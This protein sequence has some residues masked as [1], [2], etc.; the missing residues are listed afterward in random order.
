[1]TPTAALRRRVPA[2]P[3]QMAAEPVLPPDGE[4]SAPDPLTVLESDALLGALFMGLLPALAADLQA[5]HITRRAT[6]LDIVFSVVANGPEACLS[7]LACMPLLKALRGMMVS[8]AA[9]QPLHRA[10]HWHTAY[11][12][13]VRRSLCRPSFCGRSLCRRSPCCR[14]PCRRSLCRRLLCHRSMKLPRLT[15]ATHH[16]TPHRPCCGCTNRSQARTCAS[17]RCHTR[18]STASG[19]CA[20]CRARHVQAPSRLGPARQMARCT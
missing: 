7:I 12:A 16:L 17:A 6:A 15:S 3:W 14:L 19:R 13:G 10:L 18:V 2:A 8:S 5:P 9:P 1:M 11:M 20:D 4:A